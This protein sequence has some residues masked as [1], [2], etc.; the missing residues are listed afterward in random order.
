[1]K[2]LRGYLCLLLLAGVGLVFGNF[3]GA[4]S[5]PGME[6]MPTFEQRQKVRMEAQKVTNMRNGLSSNGKPMDEED[7]ES[8]QSKEA[9]EYGK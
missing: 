4:F 6:Q 1:M 5:V 8:E 7:A 3:F 2:N 9:M